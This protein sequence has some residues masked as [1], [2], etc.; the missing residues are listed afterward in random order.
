M[1]PEVATLPPRHEPER[2][3]IARESRWWWQAGLGVV[4]PLLALAFLLLPACAAP[5][6]DGDGTPDAEDCAPEDPAIHP[7]ADEACDGLDTD[8]DGE[9]P[10]EEL[11]DADGDGFAGCVDDCDDEDPAVHPGV[12]DV[13]R[14]VDDDCDGRKDEDIDVSGAA[15]LQGVM[16]ILDA[17]T[18]FV[19]GEDYPG[20]ALPLA[21]V[22]APGDV[23]ADGFDDLLVSNARGLAFLF[24]GPFCRGTYETDDADARLSLPESSAWFL[25]SIFDVGD[26]NGDGYD[27]VHFNSWVWFGPLMGDYTQAD[28]DLTFSSGHN[29][30][31]IEWLASGDWN[32]D[33]QG[34]LALGSFVAGGWPPTTEVDEDGYPVDGYTGQVALVMGPFLDGVADAATADAWLIGEGGGHDAGKAV[35]SAGDVNGDG[36]DDVIV[37]APAYRGPDGY[38]LLGATYLALSPFAGNTYLADAHARWVGGEGGVPRSGRQVLGPGDVTGDGVPDV[39]VAGTGCPVHVLDGSTPPGTYTLGVD[40][41]PVFD[42]IDGA[43]L[44]GGRG[45]LNGDGRDDFIVGA[46][47]RDALMLGTIPTEVSIETWEPRFDSTGVYSGPTY[48]R[49]VDGAILGDTT[50]DGYDDFAFVG[51]GSSSVGLEDVVA[52]FLGSGL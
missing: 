23:N 10:P 42:D 29:M 9:V 3:N 48:L 25:R 18:I 4:A 7:G 33:G 30:S 17:W 1:L 31:A 16:S 46:G 19:E 32:G 22:A 14:R 51:H 36:L 28:A 27:D 45:D 15:P 26:L 11:A 20:W 50:Q 43:G 47:M 21:E 39:V 37:G 52:V 40:V 5:D 12:V 49:T 8:C 24:Y 44:A 13:G 6:A 41:G 2:A 38:P 35:A 34:D